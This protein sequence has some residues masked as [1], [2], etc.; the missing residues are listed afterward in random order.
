MIVS[1]ID[2]SKNNIGIIIKDSNNSINCLPIFAHC[3]RSN[4]INNIISIYQKYRPSLT[5]VGLSTHLTGHLTSNGILT[6]R[7]IHKYRHIFTPFVYINE[8]NTT[9]NTQYLHLNYDINILSA[10]LIFD[11][12][13]NI[14]NI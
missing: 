11:K 7:F 4:F 12:W 3:I 10:M 2:F 13:Q 1:V 9:K 5:I 6:K 8:H 14:T